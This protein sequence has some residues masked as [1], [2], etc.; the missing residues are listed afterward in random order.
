[1]E[2][3]PVL[4][5][6]CDFI[7]CA[8]CTDWFSDATA[9]LSCRLKHFWVF[10]WEKKTREERER[11]LWGAPSQSQSKREIQR[12]RRER[13]RIRLSTE[14]FGGQTAGGP[15][16]HWR[17]K[18]HRPLAIQKDDSKLFFSFTSSVT[19]FPFSPSPGP[20][21]PLPPPFFCHPLCLCKLSEMKGDTL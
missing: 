10:V 7:S 5:G 4:C 11:E 12:E 1:M 16:C 18:T 19:P 9:S 6:P 21:A 14:K 3:S 15:V 8:V 20:F 2:I 13:E 17:S